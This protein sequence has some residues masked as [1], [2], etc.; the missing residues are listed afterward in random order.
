MRKIFKTVN[1]F[2]DFDVKLFEELNI[3]VEIQDWTNPNLSDQ[4]TENLI[5]SLIH[6]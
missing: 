5:L 1:T 6:I 2:S 4:D 3:G